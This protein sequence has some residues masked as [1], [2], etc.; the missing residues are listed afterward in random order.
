MIRWALADYTLAF[1]GDSVELYRED[2]DQSS[3]FVFHYRFGEVGSCA[4]YVYLFDHYYAVS[5]CVR[6]DYG[7]VVRYRSG[8]VHYVEPDSVDRLDWFLRS[9]PVPRRDTPRGVAGIA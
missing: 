3:S 1:F 5:Q 2:D 4:I 9:A 8:R 6:N 7:A